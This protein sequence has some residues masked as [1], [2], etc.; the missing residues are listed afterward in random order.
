MAIFVQCSIVSH[1]HT[2]LVITDCVSADP[3][4]YVPS[5]SSD[6]FIGLCYQVHGEG[7]NFYNLIT[8][9]Y[10]SVNALWTNVSSTMNVITQVA[11][12]TISGN[13]DCYFILINEQAPF[14]SISI[15]GENR[16]ASESVLVDD[17]SLFVSGFDQGGFVIRVPNGGSSPLT[18]RVD[19]EIRHV[20]L[21]SNPN[22]FRYI[23]LLKIT[24]SRSPNSPP[25]QS[26]GLLGMLHISMRILT[27]YF[28]LKRKSGLSHRLHVVL[29]LPMYIY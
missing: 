25:I 12:S 29:C 14:C 10:T 1:T 20:L 11:I 13:G 19:C 3:V 23:Q 8:T 15:N 4:F 28:S 16:D 21:E 9:P 2:A 17:G 27:A 26:H 6:S 22:V 7:G 5:I 24:V 18:I